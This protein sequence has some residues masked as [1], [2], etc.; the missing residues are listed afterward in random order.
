MNSR[1]KQR[2]LARPTP[3]TAARFRRT[4]GHRSGRLARAPEEVVE[5]E[6]EKR[7]EAQARRVKIQEALAR[8]KG[9]RVP[10]P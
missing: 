6:R 7:E 3:A 4:R 9:A 5:G 2:P 1:L 10:S 8:L